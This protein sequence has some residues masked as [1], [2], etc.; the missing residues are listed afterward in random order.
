[1]SLEGWAT[2]R[3]CFRCFFENNVDSADVGSTRSNANQK[4]YDISRHSTQT[5]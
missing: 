1:M 3:N 2:Q 4:Q 5:W